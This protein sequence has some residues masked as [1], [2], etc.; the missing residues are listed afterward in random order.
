[1]VR[2]KLVR[3]VGGA[4]EALVWARVYFRVGS[5][6]AI[7]YEQDGERW[8]AASY[9]ALSDETGLSVKQVRTAIDSLVKGEFLVREQHAGYD[10]TSSYRPVVHLPSGADGTA[11]LG[12]FHV[13]ERADVPLIDLEDVSRA[14]PRRKPEVRIPRSWAPT[15]AHIE[16]AKASGVDVLAEAERFRLH[17]ETHDRH[18]A[19]WNAAFTTWLMKAR[20]ALAIGSDPETDWMRTRA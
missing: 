12:T 7:A 11:R 1:M 8:W 4:N 3:E 6:S 16:R 19:N 18:A 5:D 9:E 15:A 13:P 2:A 20:P 10:R 17:A 14:Q